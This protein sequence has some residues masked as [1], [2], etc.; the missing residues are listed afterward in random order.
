MKNDEFLVEMGLRIAD[1]RKELHLTQ[2]QLAESID[3]SLQ[4]IS[5]IELGKKAVRPENLAKLC[6]SLNI[7][8]DYILYGKRNTEQM[9][10]LIDK[11]SSLGKEEYNLVSDLVFHFDKLCAENEQVKRNYNVYDKSSK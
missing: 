10:K 5:C 7:T 6:K 11:L 8:S 4:T 1:R 3:V 9:N 2:E